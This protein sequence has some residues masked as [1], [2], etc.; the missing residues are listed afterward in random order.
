[1]LTGARE[2]QQVR[3][4]AL[5]EGWKVVR[6]ADEHV[7][8][9]RGRRKNHGVRE[10]AV[11]PMELVPDSAVFT[12]YIVQ[13]AAR[14]R[15]STYCEAGDLLLAKIT[16]SL[17]NGKQGIVPP[18]IPNG[19]AFA[20]SEVYPIEC[21]GINNFFLFYVLKHPRYRQTLIAS[22]TGTTGR[23]RVA[24]RNVEGLRIP[25]PPLAEQER[26]AEILSTVD[27]GIEKADEA[28]EETK[29]LKRGLMQELLTRGI[30]HKEFKTSAGGRIP[31]SW[32][33]ERVSDLFDTPGGTTPSTGNER[34]WNG[35]I[36]W[37]TPTDITRLKGRIHLEDTEKRITEEAVKACSLRILEKDT[38]LLTSRAT[39]GFTAINAEPVTINQG[40]TA[41][42][43]R[44]RGSVLP[45]FYHYYLQRLRP[46]L[47][48]LGSGSTFREVSRATL[49]SI[50]IPLPPLPEQRQIAS[51]LGTV[52][53]RL[54]L[55]RKRKER[56]QRIKQGLMN[57]LLT[58]RRRVR[59]EA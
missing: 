36:L 12:G 25:L 5:L 11:I 9:V 48:Q 49:R 59:V 35:S 39:I 15:P 52:D 29:R 16:P 46:Y 30:G 26:I 43:P 45:L 34:Y 14:A 20:T 23:Q 47:N 51:I 37:V 58:G 42:A 53:A 54:D 28:I 38:I 21:Q 56:L 57:D 3:R 19:F 33:V 10:I 1:M 55:L 41:L 8:K 27:R 17:E 6:L 40:M 24:R 32:V 13:P 7:A 4:T 22:M 50:K 44:D 2:N 18:D 31:E